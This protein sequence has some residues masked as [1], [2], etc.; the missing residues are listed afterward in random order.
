MQK[1]KL[2]GL[3]PPIWVAQNL[4]APD[5]Q[6]IIN[7]ESKSCQSQEA[8]FRIHLPELGPESLVFSNNYVSQPCIYLQFTHLQFT[9]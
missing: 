3:A 1:Y 6:Y 2:F 5:I 7:S 8:I 4:Y 9:I